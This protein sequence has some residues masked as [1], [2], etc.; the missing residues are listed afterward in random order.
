MAHRKFAGGPAVRWAEIE[1]TNELRRLLFKAIEKIAPEVL[2]DLRTSV[3]P[4]YQS[5]IPERRKVRSA[6]RLS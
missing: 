2:E 3:W 4:L 1:V 5:E 6:L